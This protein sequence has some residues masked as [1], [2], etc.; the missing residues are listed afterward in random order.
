MRELEKAAAEEMGH[1]RPQAQASQG[2]AVQVIVSPRIVCRGPDGE[3][4]EAAEDGVTPLRP[5]DAPPDAQDAP[6]TPW[7]QVI[8]QPPAG[9]SEPAPILP[10]QQL[11][12]AREG[13][14]PRPT[15]GA[16]RDEGAR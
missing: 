5:L 16:C 8:G 14:D 13:D 1:R 7:G 12:S 9:E 3:V 6:G 15:D 11:E 4:W 2:P 10:M